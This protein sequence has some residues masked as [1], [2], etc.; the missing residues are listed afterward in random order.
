VADDALVAVHGIHH[1]LEDGVE[2]LMCFLGITRRHELQQVLDVRKED[3]NV[4][5]LALEPGKGAQ[6]AFGQPRGV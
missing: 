1:Q 2:H 4:L 5:A 3:R 6:D